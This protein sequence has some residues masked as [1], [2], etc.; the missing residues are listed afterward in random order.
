[1][2]YVLLILVKL[3]RLKE[4]RR[5]MVWTN[6]CAF[7]IVKHRHWGW[8]RKRKTVHGISR[9]VL[10]NLLA[11]F[12]YI[13]ETIAHRG[14][15]FAVSWEDVS[16]CSLIYFYWCTL[17]SVAH[18]LP[19]K[20]VKRWGYFDQVYIFK[21]ICYKLADFRTLVD[22]W[23]DACLVYLAALTWVYLLLHLLDQLGNFFLY[24]VMKS[25]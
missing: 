11:Y 15:S 22:V 23:M 5:A 18:E 1:M 4:V 24:L 12:L 7:N 2:H 21:S 13:D 3:Q 25:C 10:F 8:G 20:Q 9:C 17:S 16:V 6:R 19:Y 14:E